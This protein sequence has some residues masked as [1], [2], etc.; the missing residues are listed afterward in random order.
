MLDPTGRV[1][2]WNAGAECIRPEFR[3]HFRRKPFDHKGKSL[4]LC[5]RSQD[6]LKRG[7]DRE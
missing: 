7:S 6:F 5:R 3:G 1:V 2:S 4:V